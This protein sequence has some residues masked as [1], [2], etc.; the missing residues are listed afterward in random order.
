VSDAHSALGVCARGDTICSPVLQAGLSLCPSLGDGRHPSHREAHITQ[1]LRVCGLRG[2]PH[3]QTYHRVINRVVWL[4]LRASRI[5]LL[6]LV[7]TFAVSGSL[8]FGL[9]DHVLRDHGHVTQKP[10]SHFKP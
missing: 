7:T 8:V 9:D 5:L 2:T 4:S 3:F 1:A 6:L 10:P